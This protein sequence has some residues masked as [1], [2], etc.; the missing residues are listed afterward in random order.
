MRLD[1]IRRKVDQDLR[2]W[3]YDHGRHFEIPEQQFSLKGDGYQ[4]H[5]QYQPEKASSNTEGLSPFM[6]ASKRMVTTADLVMP[7]F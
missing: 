5:G 2:R 4:F 7:A 6:K 3:K 1:L